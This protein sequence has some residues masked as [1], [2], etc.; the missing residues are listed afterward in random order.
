MKLS[1]KIWL[2]ALIILIV[3]AIFCLYQYYTKKPSTVIFLLYNN[4]D[5]SKFSHPNVVPYKI[6]NQT[7]FFESEAFRSINDLPKANNIGFITPSFFRKQQRTLDDIFETTGDTLASTFPLVEA[8]ENRL[9]FLSKIHG[10]NFLIIWKWLITELGYAEYVEMDF[11]GF[12]ANMWIANRD[13]VQRFLVVIKRAIYICENAPDKMKT[14]L[15]SD[16]HYNGSIKH[17]CLEKF[18]V[19]HYPF[20]PFIMENLPCFLSHLDNHNLPF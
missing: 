14:L 11:K 2:P 16:S 19:P 6:H 20:H 13:F 5:I 9:A 4:E 10:P 8:E 15:Y 1:K 17:H 18:G 12:S 3:V 7:V